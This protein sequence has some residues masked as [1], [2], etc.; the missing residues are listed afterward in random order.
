MVIRHFISQNNKIN[1]K[2]AI[3]S[4]HPLVTKKSYNAAKKLIKFINF[5]PPNSDVVFLI[6]GGGSAMLAHPVDDLDFKDKSVFINNLLH[7]GIGEREVNFFRKRLS[8]IKSS[9]TLSYFKNANILN[10]ILS[11][12]RSNK[13][14]A[15]SSGI[16][17]PQRQI[18]IDDDLLK[19]VT[20]QKF[21]SKNICN[22]LLKNNQSKPKNFYNN[23][24]SSL[25]IGDR[26]D[27][28]KEL[29]RN[30]KN[31]TQTKN[32]SYF[33]HIFEKSF[34]T[35]VNKIYR[36]IKKFYSNGKKGLNILI[37]TGEIPVKANI[38]SKGGR[39]QH[40]SA[41]FIKKFK[42][43]NN[44][45]FCCFSTD[46]CDYLKGIHGAYI[47]DHVLEKI[48]KN[49]INYNKYIINTNTYYLHRKTKSL[50]YGEYSD[51]NFSDFYIFSFI[52]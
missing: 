21:C 31:E 38:N 50:I 9:K 7:L 40:L 48:I 27:L 15:I 43:L 26:F 37:F 44:F 1:K 24:V 18:K 35:S 4:S 14:D 5:I 11:D 36:A 8:S 34:D 20:S 51:N 22:F 33:G 39:N 10:I 29:E 28:I 41:V 12:E 52:K 30:F 25:I 3:N 19:K 17:I 42:Y 2:K 47:D 16:S 49:K 46:G 23:T 32:I 6:S 13:I 45:S